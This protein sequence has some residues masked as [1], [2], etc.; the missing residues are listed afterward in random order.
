MENKGIKSTGKPGRNNSQTKAGYSTKV[1]GRQKTIFAIF[2]ILLCVILAQGIIT[3]VGLKNQER[4]IANEYNQLIEKKAD[5]EETLQYIN[6]PEYIEQSAREMLKMVMPGEVLYVL[7]DEGE[8]KSENG[9][10]Q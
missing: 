2:G 4:K 3:C 5:L 9:N 10:G 7:R 6:T 8:G 1:K